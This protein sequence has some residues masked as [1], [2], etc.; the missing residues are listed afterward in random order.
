[1]TKR[2]IK[3]MQKFVTSVDI[4]NILIRV[5]PHTPKTEKETRDNLIEEM[6]DVLLNIQQMMYLFSDEKVE[7][8]IKSIQSYK[9]N[10]WWRRTFISQEEN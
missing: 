1:M 7:E 2:V 4:E 5:S 3:D 9:T 8:S 6:A 10:R